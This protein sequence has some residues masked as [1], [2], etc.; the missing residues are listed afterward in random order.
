MKNFGSSAKRVKNF[1]GQK[2]E[3]SFA[4]E[5]KRN[6]KNRKY[7]LEKTLSVI[8]KFGAKPKKSSSKKLNKAHILS[9]P[10]AKV[11]LEQLYCTVNQ[12]Y[13]LFSLNKT[14]KFKSLNSKEKLI[15]MRN[16]KNIAYEMQRWF[17]AQIKSVKVFKE[18]EEEEWCDLQ[19]KHEERHFQIDR[20]IKYLS[21]V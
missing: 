7:Q 6:E 4:P 18:G 15:A 12:N 14:G 5:I 1:V 9:S 16:L 17:Y 3:S 2:N 20:I 13:P 19:Q 21:D 11:P 10:G 8:N